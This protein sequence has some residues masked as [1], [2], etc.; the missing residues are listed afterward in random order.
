M[1]FLQNAVGGVAP[2]RP[3]GGPFGPQVAPQGFGRPGPQGVPQGM[4]SQMP[5]QWPQP[6][7]QQG[8]PMPQGMPQGAPP[9]AQAV[10]QALRQRAVGGPGM[11]PRGMQQAF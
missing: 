9:I 2:Q 1:S 3:N 7:P 6:G 11:R 4:P 10:A 5:Q 8:M